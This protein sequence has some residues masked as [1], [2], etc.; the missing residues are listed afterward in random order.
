MREKKNYG[1]VG[2]L[3]GGPSAERDISL[4]SGRAVSAALRESGLETVEIGEREEIEAG[5]LESG[6]DIAFIAL[7]GRFGEDGQIQSFLERRGVPYTGSGVEASR[8]ALD[9]K[10]SHRIF[11]EA[12]LPTPLQKVYGLEDTTDLPPFGLPAVVK[13]SREGSSIGL[14]IVNSP[15]EFEP[16]C[17]LAR[18]YDREIVVE[19]YIPGEEVT[20]GVLEERA[21]PVVKIDPRNPFFDYEA[22][23][24]KGMTRFSV[25]APLPPPLYREVQRVGL[26]AHR[27]LGC[28]AYS[29]VDIMISMAGEPYVLEVNTI[30]GFTETSLFPQAAREDGLEFRDLCLKL[31]DLALKRYEQGVQG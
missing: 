4:K 28:Y 23:Y 20:V 24:T 11:R 1:T 8:L 13:P 12:G 25:P 27:A 7:H 3:L 16:A 6:I 18:K 14:T 26:A 21:L 22:K 5:V 31:L 19:G 10:A 15:E 29:R 30:P 17:A 2:V 9:K